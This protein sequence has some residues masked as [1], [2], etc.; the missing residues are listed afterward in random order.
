MHLNRIALLTDSQIEFNKNK[1]RVEMWGDFE[2]LKEAVK[3]WNDIANTVLERKKRGRSKAW[4]DWEKAERA[5]LTKKEA[6][7]LE[8][9]KKREEEENKYKEITDEPHPFNSYFI[10]PDTE[11]PIDQFIGVNGATLDPVRFKF[12]CNI[13]HEPKHSYIKIVGSTDESVEEASLRVKGLFVKVFAYKSIP[14]KGWSLHMLEPQNKP[15][16]VRIAD[17]PAW[18]IKPYDV[19]DFKLLESVFEGDKIPVVGK[20]DAPKELNQSFDPTILQQIRET[21][22]KNIEDALT[23][24]L[25]HI[26]LLDE[27][28][29]IR[30]RLG[31]VCLTRFPMRKNSNPLWAIDKFNEQLKNPRILSSFATCIATKDEQLDKLFEDLNSRSK[32]WHDKIE[33]RNKLIEERKKLEESGEKLEELEELDYSTYCRELEGS[34]FREF[35]INA[36]RKIPDSDDNESWPCSIDVNLERYQSEKGK[37]DRTSESSKRTDRTYDKDDKIGLWNAVLSAKNILDINTICLDS[38]FSWRLHIQTARRL[39]NNKFGTQGNFIY[40]LRLCPQGRLV[41]SNTKEINVLSVCE[42]TKWKYWLLNNYIIEITRYE[43]WDVSKYQN[44]PSGIDIPLNKEPSPIVTYGITLHKKS[45]DEVSYNSNLEPGEVP[46]W[47]PHDF[48]DEEKTGGINSLLSDINSIIEI[49]QK[50]VKMD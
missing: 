49:I 9:R 16:K 4:E 20:E 43:Y 19:S 26:H 38:S 11:I 5:P 1:N 40:K 24:A 29:K 34:P 41:Y 7:K 17:P 44:T 3:Q 21:N 46:E 2:N 28:I 8:R 13:W 45:W 22:S 30:I 42:K 18:F 47:H 6:K 12:K 23:K 25:Q 27:E 35:K 10:V 48:V 14:I 32:D 36:I 15:H 33:A 50:N 31:H 37:I 39:S